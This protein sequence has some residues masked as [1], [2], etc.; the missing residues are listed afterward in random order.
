MDLAQPHRHLLRVEQCFGA[1]VVNVVINAAFAWLLMRSLVEI[2]LWGEVSMGGDLLAT[3]FILPFAT[4]M[5]VSRIIR[6]QV[7]SGKLPPLTS[8]QIGASGLHQ[9]SIL[10]R[11]LIMGVLGLIFAAAPLV[12]LLSL[13]DAQ[14]V[15]LLSFVG[16]KAIWAGLFAMVVSPFIAWWALAAASVDA[17]DAAVKSSAT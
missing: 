12:A 17:V 4:C 13:A 15:A 6:G 5:I 7:K 8:T 3:G 11:G 10:S 2:P 14:P 1:G 16:F 9:K